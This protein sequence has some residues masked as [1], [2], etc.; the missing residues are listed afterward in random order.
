MCAV[1]EQPSVWATRMGDDLVLLSLTDSDKSFTIKKM[2][3]ET[4]CLFLHYCWK[5]NVKSVP[6][7]RRYTPSSSGICH[8]IVF[9]RAGGNGVKRENL[10][11][12]HSFFPFINVKVKVF[13]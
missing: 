6:L 8:R 10:K 5:K 1:V 13:P 12:V 2:S 7:L 3:L 11:R 9:G 4:K